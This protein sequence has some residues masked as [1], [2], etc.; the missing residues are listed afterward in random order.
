MSFLS[1]LS[2]A[3]KDPIGNIKSTVKN[4]PN[5]VGDAVNWLKHPDQ[6]VTGVTD[7]S[8]LFHNTDG[9]LIARGNPSQPTQPQYTNN[10]NNPMQNRVAPTPQM[11]M[12]IQQQ[13]AFNPQQQ[14]AMNTMRFGGNRPQQQ[15]TP[16]Q[17]QQPIM[18][19]QMQ[20]MNQSYPQ[21]TQMSGAPWNIQRRFT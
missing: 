5:S 8:Y 3:L 7:P 18:P 1:K 6:A 21:N 13:P 15:Y 2:K 19:S 20:S 9:S 17:M 4:A 12:P 14:A 11:T 10:Y 16:P